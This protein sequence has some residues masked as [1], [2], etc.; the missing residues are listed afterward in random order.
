VPTWST[1]RLGRKGEGRS[2]VDR[3]RV[4]DGPAAR[5]EVDASDPD[6]D[7]RTPVTPDITN[8]VHYGKVP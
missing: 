7:K 8:L 6:F 1:F 4:P 2:P 5:S 3:H